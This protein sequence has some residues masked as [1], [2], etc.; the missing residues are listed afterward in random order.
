[1]TASDPR[2]DILLVE[3]YCDGEL[4][5]AAALALERRLEAE[6][7]LKAHQ[8][9][10]MAL[11]A[12]VAGASLREEAGADARQRILAAAL[13][14]GVHSRPGADGPANATARRTGGQRFSM[15]Q[16]AAAVVAASVIASGTTAFIMGRAPPTSGIAAVIAGH[17]RALLAASPFDVASSDRHTVKPWFDAKLAISP[18]VPDLAAAGFQ[19]AGG[20]VDIV[21]GKAVPVLVYKRREHLISVA[22]VPQSGAR[23]AGTNEEHSSRDGFVTE[24]WPG[25]GF[26]YTAVSDIP[27]AEL[28]A[29]CD[30][31]R[32]AAATQ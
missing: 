31:W 24:T 26:A 5:A 20:R 30:A 15:R 2:D 25:Q 27:A 11:K 4:D 13:G 7:R 8:D 9:R 1:M 16:L 32:T 29:F 21:G 23:A 14:S 3:A 10:V 18:K 22:A 12:A 17:Q 19:L 6:P 28:E